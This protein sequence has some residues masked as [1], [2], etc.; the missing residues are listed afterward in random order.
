MNIK[1]RTR[2]MQ[3]ARFLRVTHHRNKYLDGALA[4]AH[5]CV[6]MARVA[7]SLR[8][9]ADAMRG[10]STDTILFKAQLTETRNHHD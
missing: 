6:A 7:N 10:L 1:Q 5:L 8:A 4:L 3:A 9:F 2:R